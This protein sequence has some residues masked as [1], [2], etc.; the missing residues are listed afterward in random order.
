MIPAGKPPLAGLP[1]TGKGVVPECTK[2]PQ[3]TPR[4]APQR[5]VSAPFRPCAAAISTSEWCRMVH[6]GATE[7]EKAP[8]QGAEL[9][10]PALALRLVSG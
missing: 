1:Q 5:T 8:Q 10:H 4:Q 3:N 9:K 6:N 2:Q 7:N